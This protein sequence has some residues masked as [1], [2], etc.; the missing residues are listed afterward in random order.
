MTHIAIGE[1]IR[2][3]VLESIQGERVIFPHPTQLTHLQFRRFAGCP[4]CNL[5]LQSFIKRHGELVNE[6]IQEIAVFH[7]S[8]KAMLKHHSNAPFPLIAD[9][10]KSLYRTFGVESSIM[11][12]T[13]LSA[14][15]AAITGLVRLGAGLPGFGESPLGLPADFLIDSSGRVLALKYGAHAYDQW[16]VDELLKLARNARQPDLSSELHPT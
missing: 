10:M 6:G 3:G 11:S 4:I 16:A 2:P 5:H 8:K 9:P 15:R 12:V 13:N 7:S 1:V 14:L